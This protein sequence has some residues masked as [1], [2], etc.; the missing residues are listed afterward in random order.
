MEQ[1]TFET[2]SAEL[3]PI[4]RSLEEKRLALKAE[5]HKNGLWGIGICLLVGLVC[6][7]WTGGAWGMLALVAVIAAFVYYACVNA[8]SAALT[9]CYKQEVI[10]RIIST[11]CSEARFTPGGGV[12]ESVFRSSGLF[13][14]PDRYHSED[15][16]EGRLDKTDFYCAEV[17]AEERCTRTDSKGRTTEY[18][19]D[20]FRGFFFVADFHKDFQGVTRVYRDSIIKF[21]RGGTRVK[22]ENPDFEKTFDVYSSDPVEARY[23][24]TPAMM[25]RLLQVERTFGGGISLSFLQSKVL[26]AIPDRKD[27]FEA[28]VWHS[29]SDLTAVQEEFGTIR[30]LTGIV[31]E[32][33]LNIR[34]W[35]KE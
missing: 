15:L 3:T 22:L 7:I 29:L 6:T 26:I 35:S 9:A 28:S 27:H 19:V 20:I 5:G 16:I 14:S 25:E 32:L 33:Q 31:Q 23:L 17:H 10:S 11:F 30:A 12:D 18:W 2:L 21:G 34:I 1:P 24:L 8:K 4:L 13:T